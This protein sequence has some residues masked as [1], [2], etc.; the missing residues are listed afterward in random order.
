MPDNQR[1][2]FDIP[3]DVAY[4]N[5]ATTSPLP[6]AGAQAAAAALQAKAHPWT[7]TPA[8]FF[9]VLERIRPLAGEVFGVDGERIALVPAASYGLAIAARNLPLAPG[10]CVLVLEDQFPSNVYCW[11]K[12]VRAVGGEV[13]TVARPADDDW[14]TAVLETLNGPAGERVGIVALPPC[15]WT[16]GTVVD[17]VRIGASCRD[18][19]LPLV[20]DA[21]Q[22]LGA[23]PLDLAALD[24]D[25]VISASHKWCFGA[26]G[27]GFCIVHPRWLAGEPLEEN[28]LNRKGSDD[29]SGLTRYADAYRGGARTF[30]TGGVSAFFQLPVVEEGLRLLKAW[31][32]AT[33]AAH[34]AAMLQTILDTA[35][36]LGFS[37][38]PP[39]ARAPHMTGLRSR[40]VPQGLAKALAARKVYVS[41]RG[42][43]IRIAPH[44]Y[45]TPA[46]VARL[47]TALEE[48]LAEA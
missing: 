19:G 32:V 25:F 30:D 37:A 2:L 16:D 17:L 11:R 34:N 12:K 39:A 41:V 14:T 15:H 46:D 9:A 18:R 36:A 47:L 44:L 22:A 26:Y 8:D 24:A 28:W 27:M 13:L 40:Q 1:H 7:I 31:G 33:V 23:M 5:C 43:S 20:V 38:P 4:F 35:T 45:N 21:T 10:G 6:N 3:E 48:S 29:F 42:T